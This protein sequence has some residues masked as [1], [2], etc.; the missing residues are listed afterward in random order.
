MHGEQENRINLKIRGRK[1][2]EIHDAEEKGFFIIKDDF[3]GS[4]KLSK[5]DLK[6][7]QSLKVY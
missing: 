6:I 4:I 2:P 5:K 3:G 7:L 1:M